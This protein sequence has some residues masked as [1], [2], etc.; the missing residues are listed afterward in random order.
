MECGLR[1]S[2]ALEVSLGFLVRKM[3]GYCYTVCGG[4]T[5]LIK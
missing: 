2:V 3:D 5:V 4:V 1:S